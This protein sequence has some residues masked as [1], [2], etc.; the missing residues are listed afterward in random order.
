MGLPWRA[1]S[2]GLAL[3]RDIRLLPGQRN[4]WQAAPDGQ[5]M[6]GPK[7]LPPAPGD[8]E[9]SGAAFRCPGRRVR[10]RR[11]GRAGR[12]VVWMSPAPSPPPRLPCPRPGV[13]KW[14]VRPCRPAPGCGTP[15]QSLG[16]PSMGR[17]LYVGNLAYGVS[18]NDLEKMFEPYG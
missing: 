10:C 1:Y 16:S 12:A 6:T 2:K 14:F 15:R 17:K 3:D 13:R 7:W 11:L 18:S 5:A 9:T 4:G 8:K